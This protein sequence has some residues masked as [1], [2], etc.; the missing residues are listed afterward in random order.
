[1]KLNWNI[2]VGLQILLENNGSL[3]FK[4]IAKNL[5]I[6]KTQAY[7]LLTACR[8]YLKEKGISVFCPKKKGVLQLDADAQKQLKDLLYDI[9]SL[10]REFPPAGRRRYLFFELWHTPYLKNHQICAALDVSRNTCINDIMGLSEELQQA[11]FDVRVNSSVNGYSLSG[12][13]ADLRKALVW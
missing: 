7:D 4:E 6:S 5:G 9:A 12:N 8:Y 13:E 2:A 3:T 1:M 10:E 11:G